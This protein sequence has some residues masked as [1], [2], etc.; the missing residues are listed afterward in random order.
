MVFRFSGVLFLDVP[1]TST[2]KART[3]GFRRNSSSSDKAPKIRG[4]VLLNS[5]E[6]F[7]VTLSSIS[8]KSW[9][10]SFRVDSGSSMFC[11]VLFLLPSSAASVLFFPKVAMRLR[12]KFYQ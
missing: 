9:E 11:A 1:G 12:E 3:C 5:F 6:S 4:S 8:S 10:M 7:L 2:E